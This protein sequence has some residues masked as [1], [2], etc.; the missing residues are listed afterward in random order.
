[1][2]ETFVQA[3]G[4]AVGFV[5]TLMVYSYLLGDNPLY[6]LAIHVLIGIGL[7]YAAVV[8]TYTVIIPQ[9]VNPIAEI[10]AGSPVSVVERVQPVVA[11]L[12]AFLLL[13]LSR[14]TAPLG[15]VTMGFVFGVGSAVAVGGAVLGTLL[16]Q[17]GAT[18]I[19]LSPAAAPNIVAEQGSG[20]NVLAGLLIMIG[21]IAT[22]LYFYF[23]A[24]PVSE[25]KVERPRWIRASS[26]IGQAY[27]MI[28]FG[29]LFAGAIVASL[30]LLTERVSFLIQAPEEFLRLL[31]IG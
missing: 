11:L 7:G 19:P 16:P 14:Q 25:G 28:A 18:A 6:R 2:D 4:I 29:S 9:L 8:A 13:K 27:L 3:I 10:F 17:V 20:L 23:D 22:L 5:L 24:R 15:N 21:T 30:A 31:G 1:M 12:A 26:Q